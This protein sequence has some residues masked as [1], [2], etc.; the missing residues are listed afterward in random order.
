MKFNSPLSL[1][2]GFERDVY[3]RMGDVI[4]TARYIP[5]FKNE[6]YQLH[7][8]NYDHTRFIAD[9]TFKID[10]WRELDLN[11]VNMIRKMRAAE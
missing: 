10:G 6:P 7:V 5:P 8:W 4:A 3:V 11:S 9:V 1:P 2:I